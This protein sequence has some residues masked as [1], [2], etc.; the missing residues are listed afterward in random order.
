VGPRPEIPRYVEAFADRYRTILDVRPG[1][2]DMASIRFRDEEQLLAAHADPLGAYER[3]VLPAKLDLADE[4]VRRRSLLLDLSIV[5]HTLKVCCAPMVLR[6][7][8]LTLPKS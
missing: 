1:I 3:I 4:Y 2:T 6:C 7:F 5:W 8:S